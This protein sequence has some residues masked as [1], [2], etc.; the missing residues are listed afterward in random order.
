LKSLEDIPREYSSLGEI[1]ERGKEISESKLAKK[2]LSHFKVEE[3]YGKSI[4]DK[5][6]GKD[7]IHSWEIGL[8]GEITDYQK[9][10]LNK[11]L[12][13]RRKKQWA[14][15][16]G[17]KWMDGMPLTLNEIKTFWNQDMFNP[18]ED[19]KQ[20]LENLVQKGYLKFEYP[21]DIIETT[22]EYGNTHTKRAYRTDL[23]KGYNIITGK[24]SFEINKILNP[25]D[26]A[27]TLVATDMSRIYVPDGEG[28]R[29]LSERECLRLF[30]F[31][32]T[33][34]VDLPE[35]SLFDL[36]GNTVVVKVIKEVSLR[37]LS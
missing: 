15:L 36:L 8:K 30:S 7:N 25:R 11:M 37:L 3:L 20:N 18:K 28:I 27:P 22:D 6:G 4:K 14:E 19:L 10:L 16:K 1:L 21:K 5:R 35:K 33:Y 17:I 24:L 2:L 31:P 26:K 12:T 13:E 23:E 9:R 34:T 29:R 32:E